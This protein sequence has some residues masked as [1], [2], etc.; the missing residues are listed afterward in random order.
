MKFG[1]ECLKG[2]SPG[3]GKCTKVEGSV[4]VVVSGLT[5]FLNRTK[6]IKQHVD[7]IRPTQNASTMSKIVR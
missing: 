4:L 5:C 2:V 6:Y 7:T 3:E 1:R